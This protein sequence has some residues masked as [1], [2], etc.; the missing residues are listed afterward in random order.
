[1]DSNC[2]EAPSEYYSSNVNSVKR[3]YRWHGKAFRQVLRGDRDEEVE[4]GVSG[5]MRDPTEGLCHV[6]ILFMLLTSLL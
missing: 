2:T 6:L 3:L 5:G 4:E 1:M